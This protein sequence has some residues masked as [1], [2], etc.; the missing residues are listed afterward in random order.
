MVGLYHAH[1]KSQENIDRSTIKIP[2]GNIAIVS[3]NL[4]NL[5]RMV[6]YR[7]PIYIFGITPYISHMPHIVQ[8]I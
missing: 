5:Y 8:A 1:G 6:F 7:I 4:L 3:K 2:S